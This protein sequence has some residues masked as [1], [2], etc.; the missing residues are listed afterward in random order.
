[1]EEP[2]RPLL[3]L[4]RIYTCGSTYG[5]KAIRVLGVYRRRSFHLESTTPSIP[6]LLAQLGLRIED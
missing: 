1:M 3:I 2:L 4:R 6:L 5:G